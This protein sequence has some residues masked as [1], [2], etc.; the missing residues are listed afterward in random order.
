MS[1][2]SIRSVALV[3]ASSQI[4]KSLVPMLEAAGYVVHRISRALPDSYLHPS[5]HVFDEAGG[6]FTPSL[7]TTQAVI[8]LAPLPSIGVVIKMAVSLQAKRIIA[9]GSTGRFSKINSASDIERDFA[10]QQKNA[11]LTLSAGCKEAKIAWTLFRPTMIYGADTDQNV[12][13]IASMIRKFGFFPLPWGAKGL[14]QP[15]HIDD[16][17][18]AC[19]LVF[20][21]AQCFDK[22]YNLGGGEVLSLPELIKKIFHTEGKI[23]FI[24]PIPTQL[25]S[26]L[27]KTA[28]NFSNAA[29]V[30]E[31]MVFRM[32]KDLTAD[33]SAANL[34]FGYS[35]RP[36]LPVEK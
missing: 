34:D 32:Y 20:D 14:R 31:E 13:F 4:G 12:A 9:F 23:P 2:T 5:V 6:Q 16:L 36:F 25:F 30:R 35:P 22:A 3:G 27:I 11:E 17:A 10:I 1:E 15:V 19:M 28:Q 18:A 24:I 8:S 7:A 21:C 26:A 29:F 33:N